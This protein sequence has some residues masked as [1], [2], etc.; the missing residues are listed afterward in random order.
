M[1]V[2]CST[3]GCSEWQSSGS[4]TTTGGDILVNLRATILRSRFPFLVMVGLAL[5]GL[6]CL[7]FII[8]GF[9]L[10]LLESGLCRFMLIG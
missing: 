2:V 3:P 8:I 10:V 9:V 7:L 6:P 5:L 4:D 1:D